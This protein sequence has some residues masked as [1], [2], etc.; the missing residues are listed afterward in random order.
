MLKSKK[1]ITIKARDIESKHQRT[2]TSELSN[3]VCTNK[4][5]FIFLSNPGLSL[6]LSSSLELSYK[7][8]DFSVAFTLK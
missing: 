6:S 7:L 4:P 2:E 3:K 8:N 1:K 5:K